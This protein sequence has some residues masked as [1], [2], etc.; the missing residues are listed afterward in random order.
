MLD[1]TPVR[2]VLVAL[3]LATAAGGLP[4]GAFPAAAV[5]GGA[6]PV[7]S[8]PMLDADGDGVADADDQCTE[9][10]PGDLVDGQGCGLSDA[11]PCDETVDLDPWGS[12]TAYVLCV[13]AAGK[14]MVS[15]GAHTRREVRRA[16]RRHKR[17]TCGN[18]NL[19]RCCVYTS[20][21]AGD[22]F[23]QCMQVTIDRCDAYA[24][25]PNVDGA[26]DIGAGLCDP[27]ACE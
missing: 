12:H 13:K 20:N 21:D 23:T 6:R 3:V 7:V 4:A 24:D 14:A 19:T 8:D 27:T 10:E 18:D 26:D 9:T 16:V 22:S 5:S 25:D 17:S 1:R 2:L 11:C 15:A